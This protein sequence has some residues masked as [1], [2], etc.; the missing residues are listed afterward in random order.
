MKFD[1]DDRETWPQGMADAF[2][3]M[4]DWDDDAL[5]WMLGVVASQLWR[6]G[7]ES[8]FVAGWVAGAKAGSEHSYC[9]GIGCCRSV[10]DSIVGDPGVAMEDA[11]ETASDGGEL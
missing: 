11:I 1:P 9:G 5:T 3:A 8:G 7:R 10:I 6:E 2:D 4:D